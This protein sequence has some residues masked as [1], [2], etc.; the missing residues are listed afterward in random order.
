MGAKHKLE[1]SSG[2]S[3]MTYVMTHVMSSRRKEKKEKKEKKETDVLGAVSP[4][5]RK[6]ALPKG[7]PGL[8]WLL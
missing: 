4:E 5:G 2:P 7:A 8:G 3:E 1:F 6:G